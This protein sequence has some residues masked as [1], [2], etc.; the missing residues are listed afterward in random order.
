LCHK[1]WSLPSLRAQPELY[2]AWALFGCQGRAAAEI[3]ARCGRSRRKTEDEEEE[4]KEEEDEEIRAPSATRSSAAADKLV[5]RPGPS[6]QEAHEDW[7][8]RRCRGEETRGH[9]GGNLGGRASFLDLLRLRH[10]LAEVLD[11]RA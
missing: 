2:K 1:I 5:V 6:V 9:L 8:L 3:L 4:E 10:L 7:R 11:G